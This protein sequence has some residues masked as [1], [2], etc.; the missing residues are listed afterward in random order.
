MREVDASG[1]RGDAARA[2]PPAGRRIPEPGGA[3][4]ENSP[5]PAGLGVVEISTVVSPAP[6]ATKTAPARSLLAADIATASI[7]LALGVLFLASSVRM[8]I[9]WGSDGPE[10]GF[11]P[12]WLSTILVLCCAVIVV[13]AARRAS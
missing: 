12:F 5:G 3:E 9:G 2:P 8:G 11:V 4:G 6:A 1:L 7:L 13:Q 10:S